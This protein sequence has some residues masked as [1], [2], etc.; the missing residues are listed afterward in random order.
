MFDD[1]STSDYQERPLGGHQYQHGKPASWVLVAVI[2][3]AFVAGGVAIVTRVWWLFWTC[4]G[5]VALSVPAGKIIGIMND[6]VLVEEG[7]RALPPTVGPG[8]A[9]DPGVRLD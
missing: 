6:T 4:A 5:I 1:S 3:A 7:P 9:A 2:I 8:S